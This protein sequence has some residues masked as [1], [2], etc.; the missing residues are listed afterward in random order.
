MLSGSALAADPELKCY[1]NKDFMKTID[2]KGLVTLYNGYRTDNKISEI[3]MSKDRFI[4][5][6]EYDKATDGNAFAAKQYCIIGLL[7]EVTFNETA[8]EYLYKLLEKVRGQK[9]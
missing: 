4:Y 5:M 9:T 2:E 6:I 3:M 7:K 1:E 8:I